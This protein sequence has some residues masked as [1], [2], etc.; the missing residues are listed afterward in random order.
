LIQAHG[1]AEKF[2]MLETSDKL[3]DL[4]EKL[5]IIRLRVLLSKSRIVALSDDNLEA[6]QSIKKTI[7]DI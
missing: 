5:N 7:R 4:L 1:F 2:E 6:V 3:Y